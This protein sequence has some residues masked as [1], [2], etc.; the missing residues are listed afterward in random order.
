MYNSLSNEEILYFHIEITLR[1]SLV[2]KMEHL[3]V[4]LTTLVEILNTLVVKIVTLVVII[5]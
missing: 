2:V 5:K 3:V 1:K 4:I